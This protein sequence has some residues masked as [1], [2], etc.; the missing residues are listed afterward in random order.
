MIRQS[1]TRLASRFNEVASVFVRC[2]H[3]TGV[4][5]NADHGIDHTAPFGIKPNGVCRTRIG[6]PFRQELS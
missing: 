5:V 4:I 1:S 3:V 6:D 2:D